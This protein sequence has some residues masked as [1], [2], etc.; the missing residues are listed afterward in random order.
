LV[1]GPTQAGK[2]SSL[3][4]PTLLRWRGAVVVTRVKNDVIEATS[5]WR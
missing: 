5:K 2:T 3:V 1:V 4:V